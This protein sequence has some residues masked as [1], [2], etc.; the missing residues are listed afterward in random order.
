MGI[1]ETLA[2]RGVGQPIRGLQAAAVANQPMLQPEQA[3]RIVGAAAA[4]RAARSAVMRRAE[5]LGRDP[6]RVAGLADPLPR[7]L[8]HRIGDN[9]GIG[10]TLG[11]ALLADGHGKSARLEL[12]AAKHGPKEI[13]DEFERRLVIVMKND[14]EVADCDRTIAHGKTFKDIKTAG[15]PTRRRRVHRPR[16]AMIDGPIDVT[17]D[18]AAIR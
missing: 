1:F 2:A 11:L 10:A 15:Y 5:R 8:Q 13:D 4:E 16:R 3:W 7:R 14:L 12:R 17:A 6:Q 18:D 9:G